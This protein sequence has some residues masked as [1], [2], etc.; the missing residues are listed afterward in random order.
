MT[1]PT[2]E[3]FTH[4]AQS[5]GFDEIVVREW[6]P[7]MQVDE[8]AHPFDVSALVV[9]GEFWL[10]VS[11]E[12]RHFGAGESF[13]LNRLIPHAEQYGPQGATVW[14]GRAS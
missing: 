9:R 4:T 7:D 6:A 3:Q 12:T 10:T 5:E 11:G 2:L 13:R 8:H 1:L 14:V